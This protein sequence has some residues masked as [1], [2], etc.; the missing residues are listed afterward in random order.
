MATEIL[1]SDDDAGQRLDRWLK[2]RDVPFA[3][4]Q[5]ALRTGEIRVNSK[6]VDGAVR[7]HAGD[8]VRLPPQL[9]PD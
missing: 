3:G 8:K 6:R 4:L 7:L 9:Q 2:A 5:K 1:V